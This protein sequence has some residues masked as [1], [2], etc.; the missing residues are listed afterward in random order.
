MSGQELPP[1]T[2]VK[3]DLYGWLRDEIDQSNHLQ[4]RITFAQAVLVGLGLGMRAMTAMG[5]EIPPMAVNALGIAIL[6]LPVLIFTSTAVW[7]LEQAR[8]MR[9]GNYLF[10]LE[11]YINDDLEGQ[12]PMS[13]ETWLRREQEYRMDFRSGLTAVA[14]SKVYNVAFHIGYPL[15]FVALAAISGIL[16]LLFRSTIDGAVAELS[17]SL[18]PTFGV[19]GEGVVETL[20]AL[21]VWGV[22]LL[23]CIATVGLSVVAVTQ[24]NHE[25]HDQSEYDDN[26]AAFLNDKFGSPS[27]HRA[28]DVLFEEYSEEVAE[29]E[30]D[31]TD[32]VTAFEALLREARES[33]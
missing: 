27:A 19:V 15:Y 32:G 11:S 5:D 20:V 22:P 17:A 33:N 31:D 2:R 7:L 4:N 28:A 25:R 16:L 12:D 29:L 30:L 26:F 1:H 6:A 10:H 24:I 18:V 23:G 21:V 14:P 3:L 13:W 8:V 9:A